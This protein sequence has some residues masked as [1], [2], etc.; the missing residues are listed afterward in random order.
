MFGVLLD[1][2][3]LRNFFVLELAARQ[4][5][6]RTWKKQEMQLRGR[7]SLSAGKKQS[8]GGKYGNGIRNGCGSAI[9]PFH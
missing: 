1:N 8:G 3:Q 4:V 5:K 2:T 9:L 7:L 6:F